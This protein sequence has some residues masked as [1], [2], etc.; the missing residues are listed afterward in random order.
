MKKRSSDF[1]LYNRYFKLGTSM[2]KLTILFYLLSYSAG[3]VTQHLWSIPGPNE[4]NRIASCE[5]VD[6]DSYRVHGLLE[7]EDKLV[8]SLRTEK[9]FDNDLVPLLLVPKLRNLLDRMK[10]GS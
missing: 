5:L 9:V 2:K 4:K 1:Y 7:V 6:S 8:G 3:S 10:N